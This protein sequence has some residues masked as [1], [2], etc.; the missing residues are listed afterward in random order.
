MHPELTVGASPRAST[1]LLN[2]A[3]AHAVLCGRE[4]LTPVDVQAMFRPAYAHRVA[5]DGRV[6]TFAARKILEGLLARCPVPRP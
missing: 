5:V 2:V 4:Y 6:D 1:S 3:R